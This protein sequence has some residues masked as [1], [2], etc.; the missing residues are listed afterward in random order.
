MRHADAS[1]L[2]QSL[3]TRSNVNAIAQKVAVAFNHVTD[4]DSNS[5]IHLATG[6][7]CAISR[8]QTF[9]N[10]NCTPHCVD[11]AGEFG[12]DGVSSRVEYSAWCPGNEIVNDSAIGG[13]PV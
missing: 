5:E 3:E 13:K 11:C 2:C 8:A 10:I 1:R 9:L 7:V 12:E 4:G 6:W